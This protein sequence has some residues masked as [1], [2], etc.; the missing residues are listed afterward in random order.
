MMK[1]LDQAGW[2]FLVLETPKR[3]AKTKKCDETI[4]HILS[5]VTEYR[6][7]FVFSIDFPIFPLMG[8]T[9]DA[10]LRIAFATTEYNVRALKTARKPLEKLVNHSPSARDL[11]SLLMLF[12]YPTWLIEPTNRT[13]VWS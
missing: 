10:I 12:Q 2:P 7:H 6:F 3:N 5:K 13:N 8:F 4:Y 11:Q 9:M 1:E